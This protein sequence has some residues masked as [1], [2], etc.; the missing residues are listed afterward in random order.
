MKIFQ[1]SACDFPVFFENTSCESCDSVLGYLDSENEMFARKPEDL[2]WVID[3]ETYTNCKNEPLGICNWLVPITSETGFCKSCHLNRTIPDVS[4]PKLHERLQNMEIAK[5]RLIYTLERLGLPV[6]SQFE[7]AENGLFFDFLSKGDRN[8]DGDK[9]MTGHANGV[10]TILL[11]EADDVNREQMRV[12]LNEKYRTV[13]GH[14]R[15]E[16][17]HYYWD[18]I[19]RNNDTFLADFRK[20]FGDE[21][22]SYADAL[23]AHYANGAPKDWKSRFI[24]EY[25]SAHP[26]EDWAET[27]AHYLH[28]LDTMETAFYFGLEGDPNLR[29][30][31]HMRVVSLYPYNEDLSFKTI[32]E[33][34]T[35]L[36]YAVNSINRSMGITDVYPFVISDKVKEKLEFIHEILQRF[37]AES[38]LY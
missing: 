16:V 38:N 11:A 18:V 7:N 28:I 35:P 9:V 25:A 5:H 8:V 30:S 15:H 1:C 20:L 10:V 32:L 19:F 21:S 29:N 33:E 37:K 6:V 4:I 26:W 22:E 24:S 2:N 31:P 13:I 36:F 34:T 27:W 23:K 17:G 12:S 3:G 14:F